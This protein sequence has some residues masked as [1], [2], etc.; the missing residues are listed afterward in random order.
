MAKFHINPSTGNANKCSATKQCPFGDLDADHYATKEEATRAYESK[1]AAS[2][3]SAPTT[4]G[5]PILLAPS[6][7]CDDNL[8]TN[9]TYGVDY[10]YDDYSCQG[11]DEDICRCRTF[12][13]LKLVGWAEPD[14]V[15]AY[16]RSRL[17]LPI[18]EEFPK[19]LADKLKP[20]EDFESIADDF[21][22]YTEDDYYGEIV[23]VEPSPILDTIFSDYLYS[24]PNAVDSEGVLPYLRTQGFDTTGL[25]PIQAIEAALKQQ[26]KELAELLQGVKGYRVAKVEERFIK[27][28]PKRMAEGRKDPRPTVAYPTA[29]QSKPIAGVLLRE[30]DSEYILLDG[31]KRA[32]EFEAQGD[33]R[34]KDYVILTKESKPRPWDRRNRDLH[35][36]VF[37][38]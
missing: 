16:A 10:D 28:D 8:K 13:G 35:R 19:D 37:D 33:Q 2:L 23:V 25:K 1:M 26:H 9:V 21:R 15:Y 30:S 31:F 36:F 17:G 27:R 20:Y 32:A 4:F 5:P 11:C 38:S 22:L 14:G 24:Q 12:S 3:F 7:M 18:A 6:K 29:G 34:S